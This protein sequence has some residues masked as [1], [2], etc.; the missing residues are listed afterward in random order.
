MDQIY[1]NLTAT[2][3]TACWTL[4]ALQAQRTFETYV[5][6]KHEKFV[7]RARL[8]AM[9]SLQSPACGAACC[10]RRGRAAPVRV[11]AAAA[12]HA[13]APEAEAKAKPAHGHGHGGAGSG[14]GSQGFVGEMRKA[15]ARLRRASPARS[16]FVELRLR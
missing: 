8:E 16:R 9:K 1:L 5:R 15:R 3:V 2:F 11:A 7:S 6:K 14:V 13:H 4:L 12:E 10:R